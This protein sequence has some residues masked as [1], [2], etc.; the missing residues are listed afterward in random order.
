[1]RTRAGL[2]YYSYK[3]NEKAEVVYRVEFSPEGVNG[4]ENKWSVN[5]LATGQNDVDWFEQEFDT[6]KDALAAVKEVQES[7]HYEYVEN[8]GWC[9][10][11]N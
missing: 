5:S 7:G 8:F 3:I 4:F 9:Y 2:Y 1:M 6:K 10:F 11:D